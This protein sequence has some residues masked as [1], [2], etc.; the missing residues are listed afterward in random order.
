MCEITRGI[1]KTPLGPFFAY[2]TNPTSKSVP[3]QRKHTQQTKV[4]FRRSRWGAPII[5]AVAWDQHPGSSGRLLQPICHG[6]S[7]RNFELG[8]TFHFIDVC[9]GWRFHAPLWRPIARSGVGARPISMAET[10]STAKI[11]LRK[12]ILRG[13]VFENRVPGGES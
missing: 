5:S 7:R 3:D 6:M 13:S 1:P 8:Q 11:A 12:L 10:G 2:I 9:V 4:Q